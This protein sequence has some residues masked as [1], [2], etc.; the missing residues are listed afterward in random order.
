[1]IMEKFLVGLMTGPK[2]ARSDR[3]QDVS[4]DHFFVVSEKPGQFVKTENHVIQDK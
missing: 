3:G 2:V 1:M 4:W